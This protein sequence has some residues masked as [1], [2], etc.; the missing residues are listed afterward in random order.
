MISFNLA[1]A[2]RVIRFS[3][4]EFDAVFFGFSFEQLRDELFPIIEINLS[5]DPTFSESPLESIDGRNSIFVKIDFAFHAVSGTIIGE[6]SDIDF[7]NTMDSELEGISLPHAVNMFTLKPFSCGLW[8]CFDSNEK[9]VFLEDTMY[10]S[11]G[12]GKFELVLDPSG[13][14]CRIFSFEPNDPLFQG[15]WYRFP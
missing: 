7:A 1:A 10:R 9:S 11:P 14:P 2:A 5:W 8:F 12:T 3:K 6:P 4:D 13:S 15:C